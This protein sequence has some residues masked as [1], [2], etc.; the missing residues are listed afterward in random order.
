M[1]QVIEKQ[2]DIIFQVVKLS[3]KIGTVLAKE[4]TYNRLDITLDQCE[5][6]VDLT[7]QNGC[8]LKEFIDISF[9]S[10]SSMYRL[11]NS[12]GKN[13]LIFCRVDPTDR[14]TKRI[15][16]TKKGKEIQKII[17]DSGKRIQSKVTK[18]TISIEIDI[19][20]ELMQ[21]M[22]AKLNKNDFELGTLWELKK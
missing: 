12:M 22:S 17:I 9:K 4:I 3:N 21:K 1:L 6:L 15:Y 5:I 8:S 7:L 2:N 18:R 19:M 14:R 10:R 20:L 13:K 11:I 16:T